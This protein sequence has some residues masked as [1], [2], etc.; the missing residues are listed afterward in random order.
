MAEG[1]YRVRDNGTLPESLLSSMQAVCTIF[2]NRQL[3]YRLCTTVAEADEWSGLIM[4]PSGE[5]IYRWGLT[6]SELDALD[7]S[8]EGSD[9]ARGHLHELIEHLSTGG[10]LP[11]ETKMKGGATATLISN[12]GHLLTNHH[13]V[14]GIQR[15][16]QLPDQVVVPDGV[17]M[18]HHKIQTS[19]GL[20]LG[21]VKL[22][23]VDKSMDLAILKVD[24]P[25]HISPVSTRDTQVKRH[26]R[27]WH[28]GYPQLTRRPY[29][30]RKFFWVFGC[31]V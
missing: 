30:Q 12:K 29:G 22:C 2:T 4:G 24:P 17:P 5:D 6:Q 10:A 11:F 13:L 20:D 18:P 15:F 9:W 8:E 23:Y 27:V 21:P 31:A 19:D 28:L 1:F 25:E 16:H 14:M 26:E 7:L 3:H